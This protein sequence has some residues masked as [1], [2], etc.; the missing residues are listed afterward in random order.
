ML[1]THSL[2]MMNALY[3]H[4]S[5]TAI[6]T[7]LCAPVNAEVD[8]LNFVKTS[9][10]PFCPSFTTS[11]KGTKR[12]RIHTEKPKVSCFPMALIGI[13]SAVTFGERHNNN[14]RKSLPSKAQH[15]LQNGFC[16]TWLSAH[17]RCI[18]G[19]TYSAL[20]CCSVFQHWF[21]YY[22]T[23]YCRCS[24]SLWNRALVLLAV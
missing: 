3:A 10:V 2:K 21:C 14:K 11:Q 18:A 20:H 16:W 19:Q 12:G 1:C 23:F 8:S 22:L 9:P 4:S 17:G 5:G 15:H 7:I 6:G 24:S 13:I